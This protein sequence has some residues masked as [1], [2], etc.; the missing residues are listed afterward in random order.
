MADTDWATRKAREV[1]RQ[2]GELDGQ[3]EPPFDDVCE[4]LIA[5]ALRDVR[6]EGLEECARIADTQA[7]HAR[8]LKHIQWDHESAAELGDDIANDIRALAAGEK[9]E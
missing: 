4:Q 3:E 2:C 1:V 9:A 8:R 6:R 5:S 7:K